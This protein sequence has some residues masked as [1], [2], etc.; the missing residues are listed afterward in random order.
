MAASVETS[1]R[2]FDQNALE[3]EYSGVIQ[4]VMLP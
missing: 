2:N 1:E 4:T 3:P